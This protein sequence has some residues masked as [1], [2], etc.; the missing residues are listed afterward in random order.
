MGITWDGCG[1]EIEEEGMDGLLRSGSDEF[2]AVGNV[3][4]SN[5]G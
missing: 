5:I 3:D 4:G 1:A 2:V